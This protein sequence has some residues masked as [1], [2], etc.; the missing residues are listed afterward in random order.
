MTVKGRRRIYY[1]VDYE[2]KE[3]RAIRELA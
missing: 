1:N 3:K 2:E